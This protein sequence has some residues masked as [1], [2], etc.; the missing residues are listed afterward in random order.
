MAKETTAVL[1]ITYLTLTQFCLPTR[2]KSIPL[3][4]RFKLSVESV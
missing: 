4:K 2:L 1:M 3:K